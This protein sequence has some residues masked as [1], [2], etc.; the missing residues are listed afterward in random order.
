MSSEVLFIV[1]L[2]AFIILNVFDAHST[3]KVIGKTNYRSE[4]N[5]IA[6]L[7]FKIVGAKIGVILLKCI[8]IPV[9]FLMFYYFTF[10]KTEMNIVLGIA[11]IF[12]LLVV[13]HNYRVFNRLKRH[14]IIMKELDINDD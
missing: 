11:N 13:I 5:P 4:K 3:L 2:I 8:L 12:Y 6:R 7:L 10:K 9:I 1:L 14:E